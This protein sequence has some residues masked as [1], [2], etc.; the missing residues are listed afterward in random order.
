[1]AEDLLDELPRPQRLALSYAPAAVRSAT[2]GLLALDARLG[3]I[4]RRRG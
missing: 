3:A 4:L 1:M 2:L